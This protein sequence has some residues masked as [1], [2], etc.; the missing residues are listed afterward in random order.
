MTSNLEPRIAQAISRLPNLDPRLPADSHERGQAATLAERMVHYHVPGVSVAVVENC[1]LAWARARGEI[2]CGSGTPVTP[3]TMFESG[4]VS[5]FPVAFAVLR[6]VERGVLN[7]DRDVND[8]LVSWKIPKT[9]LTA[10]ERVTLRRLLTHTSGI[11]SA[12]QTSWALG[13][14][15]TLAQVLAGKRPATNKP[16]EV[17]TIPGSE[18]HYANAGYILIQQ[19]LEDVVGR[20]LDEV[21]RVEVFEPLGMESSTYAPTNPMWSQSLHAHPHRKDGSA[22]QSELH[23]SAFAQGGL[24]TTPTDLARFA[25][26]V[27]LAAVGRSALLS[28][29]MARQMLTPQI[30]LNPAEYDWA[31]SQGLGVFLTGPRDDPYFAHPGFS[32]PGSSAVILGHPSTGFAVAMQLNAWGGQHLELELA[33][34]ILAA[35]DRDIRELIL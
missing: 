15:P 3:E 14:T 34:S 13:S 1:E 30:A 6:L 2:R 20:P 12:D 24:L 9:K 35:Y 27:M 11:P 28:K 29:D 26:E 22:A 21:M 8:D 5:K 16:V 33:A 4:S 32:S 25:R 23:P 31:H 7:L 19:L 17:H 10:T 18:H